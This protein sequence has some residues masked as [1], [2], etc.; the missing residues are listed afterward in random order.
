MCALASGHDRLAFILTIVRPAGERARSQRRRVWLKVCLSI[1]AERA[2]QV[3][4]KCEASA[5][6]DRYF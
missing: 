1:Q 3:S 5:N 4:P 2:V 6:A